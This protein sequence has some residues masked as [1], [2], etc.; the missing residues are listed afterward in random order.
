MAF[1]AQDGTPYT[2]KPQA[3]A[4]DARASSKSKAVGGH[5][6]PGNPHGKPVSGES[7]HSAF[8]G[9]TINCPHCGSPIDVDAIH[10]QRADNDVP[11]GPVMGGSNEF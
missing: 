4:H 2:N 8:S 10:A 7:D 11:G 1:K 6:I 3:R 5:P 9:E